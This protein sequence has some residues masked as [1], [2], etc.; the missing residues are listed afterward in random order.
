[1]VFHRGGVRRAFVLGAAAIGLTGCLLPAP[2]MLA[3]YGATGVVLLETGKTPTDHAISAVR[4]EDCALVR[5]LR[6]EA[7]CRERATVDTVVAEADMDH[8]TQVPADI[9]Q[10]RRLTRPSRGHD[11]MA[12][13]RVTVATLPPIAPAASTSAVLP[14]APAVAAPAA[15]PAAVPPAR[16]AAPIGIAAPFSPDRVTPAVPD[17]LARLAPVPRP[18]RPAGAEPVPGLVV[19]D[20]TVPLP[21]RRPGMTAAGGLVPVPPA[22]PDHRRLRGPVQLAAAD[23]Q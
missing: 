22:L 7:I 8:G 3:S 4:E 19:A 12:A 18:P 15:V 9:G 13:D 5:A 14:D 2:V 6:R 10:P 11:P 23:G 21:P 1:M 17:R 20:I 16:T